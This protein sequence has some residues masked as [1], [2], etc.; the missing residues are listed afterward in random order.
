MDH[1]CVLGVKQDATSDQI[2]KAYK[3]LARKWHPDKN[4]KNQKEAERKFKDISEAHR[5]LS[6]PSRKREYDLSRRK[7]NPP[8]E[9]PNYNF[10]P[11][12]E[13]P[14][15]NFNPNRGRP[16]Q[17]F[18]EN[19]WEG[20]EVPTYNARRRRA[21]FASDRRRP[22]S[23]HF[24]FT[25]F[26]N[27]QHIRPEDMF[28]DFFERDPF[29][30]IFGHHERMFQGG[31]FDNHPGFQKTRQVPNTNRNVPAQTRRPRSRSLFRDP[32]LDFGFHAT[33]VFREFDEM[34]RL[35]GSLFNTGGA[36]ARKHG[37]MF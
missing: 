25:E 13:T 8:R 17:K 2:K 9:T 11:N 19:V 31:I 32:F 21:R 33:S 29:K 22:D 20:D 30:D 24:E 23:Q 7:P 4:P 3:V 12:R 34:D 27:T 15:Y 26:T 37:A 10:N 5:V 1:Y 6:D 18:E 16:E 28:K 36:N 35:F 14:N